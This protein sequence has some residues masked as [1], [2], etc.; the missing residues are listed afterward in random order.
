MKIE[1]QL[2]SRLKDAAGK[3]HVDLVLKDSATVRDLLAELFAQFPQLRPWEQSLLVGAGV[4]F[5]DRDYQLKPKE[6]ISVMPP[7]Q[8]G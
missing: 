6:E 2:F 1:V 5:V 7:V 3:E 8:G 4:E